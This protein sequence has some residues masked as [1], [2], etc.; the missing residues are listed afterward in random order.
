[1][2]FH[3][4]TGVVAFLA[5]TELTAQLSDPIPQRVTFGGLILETELYVTMPPSSDGEPRGKLNVMRALPD[6]RK[7][8]NDMR[9]TLYSFDRGASTTYLDLR[10]SRADLIDSPGLG[11]GFHSFAFHPDFASNGKFY[12]AHSEPWDTNGGVIDFPLPG[13]P[14]SSVGYQGILTEWTAVD[15]AADTF[16]GSS[17]EVF[18]V[19]FP[20]AVHGLQE[21]VFN[22]G[23]EPGDPDYGKL[24]VCIGEGG[25]YLA[26]LASSQHRL[27][28]PLGTIFRI[29]PLG[30]NSANGQ[31]SIPP[32]NPWASSND[33]GVLGEIYAF[34]FRN[35]HR[36]GWASGERSFMY[37]GD[38][39]ER[40]IE[41]LNIVEAGGDYGFPEREGTFRLDPD[42]PDDNYSVYSPPPDDA[43]NPFLYPVAQ[44]DHDDGYAIVAGPVYRGFGV[45]A[46]NGLLLFGD[47]RRGRVFYVRAA[48]LQQGEQAPIQEARLFLDGTDETLA[49]RTG[50]GRADLHWG[51][52]ADGELYVLTKTDGV[53]RRIVSARIEPTG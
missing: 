13:A 1:M 11:T 47:I 35:P 41:E 24:Y 30:N 14:L 49:S 21:I 50:D 31:Y 48:E 18:R 15:P 46:L 26:G 40:N 45:P 2:W 43:R 33:P 9:G 44:Y 17:R 8:V 37:V 38:I 4:F 20:G 29:D 22:P 23:A 3:S 19:Y 39:G 27:D 10:T 36:I 5:A 42:R 51:V 12:T 6:G 16:S 52:D 25:S 7:F 34:G 28:S 53:I 32:D